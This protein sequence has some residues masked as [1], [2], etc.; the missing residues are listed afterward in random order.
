[1]PNHWRL[2]MPPFVSYATQWLAFTSLGLL[3]LLGCQT[4]SGPPERANSGPL[5]NPSGKTRGDATGEIK[6]FV[7]ASTKDPI[8]EL[9]DLFSRQHGVTVSI[10]A[11]DSA[12]LA[13]QIQAGAPADLFLSA[14]EKWVTALADDDLVARQIR[15]LGNRLV[16]IAPRSS[17]DREPPDWEAIL[18]RANAR[19]AVAGANV[20]AGMYARQALTHHGWLEKLESQQRL[21][22]GENVRGVLAIVEQGEADLGIVYATDAMLSDR[23]VLVHTFESGDHQE[24]VYPLAL[25]KSSGENQVAGA[26]FEFLQSDEAKAVF[27]RFGFL[28]PADLGN[29]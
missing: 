25:L 8:R 27:E 20:P 11:D 14:S 23:V 5:P 7:A 18:K 12:R 22:I 2:L 19:V 29:R 17:D 9:A 21:V 26:W 3:V 10:T 16:A 1:M 6:F 4:G 24:I 28:V 15:L 13:Q